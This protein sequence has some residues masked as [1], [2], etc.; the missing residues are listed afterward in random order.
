MVIVYR[1]NQFEKCLE[2]LK[3]AGGTGTQAARRT[4]AL[5]E[6]L[7]QSD[8]R[9]APETCRLTRHGEARIRKCRKYDLGDGYRLV[10]IRRG[11]HLVL[12]YA[13]SHD[14]CDRWLERNRGLRPVIDPGLRPIP[15]VERPASPL[16]PWA[17][18]EGPDDPEEDYERLIT[19]RIT[20][21]DLKKLFEG[22][23]DK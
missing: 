22:L 1:D 23:W 18:A 2:Q 9:T 5:I 7:A 13:G 10:C 21:Q 17:A 4:E 16:P 11:H 14:D 8:G 6:E 15:P 3:R 20:K 12:L 19:A